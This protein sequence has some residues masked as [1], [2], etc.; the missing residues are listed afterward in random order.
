MKP[1]G[2]SMSSLSQ[3]MVNLT[4]LPFMAVSWVRPAMIST[5]RFQGQLAGGW[6][7][8]F[9]NCEV[10]TLTACFNCSRLTGIGV[11]LRPWLGAGSC[12]APSGGKYGV[13]AT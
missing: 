1:P 13:G 5:V 9:G 12:G 2:V 8:V 10:G 3:L 4:S 11:G 6:D 7:G